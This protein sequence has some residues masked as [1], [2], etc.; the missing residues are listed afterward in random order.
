MSLRPL[1]CDLHFNLDAARQRFGLPNRFVRKASQ[2]GRHVFQPRNVIGFGAV[3]GGHRHFGKGRILRILNHGDAARLMD[4]PQPGGAVAQSAGE[5]DSDRAGTAAHRRRTQHWVDGGTR[6][7]FTRAL[8][9]RDM[10]AVDN[11]VT[12]RR[13]S[14]N[15][16]LS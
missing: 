6:V 12:I 4:G 2:Q 13:R 9:K 15:V 14:I 8:A 7:I 5:D 3:Q 10:I 1:S 16:R 11:E